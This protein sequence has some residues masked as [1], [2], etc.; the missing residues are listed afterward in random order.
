VS[1]C[2]NH[3]GASPKSGDLVPYLVLRL[4]GKVQV[5]REPFASD[6]YLW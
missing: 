6:F 5:L 3:Q 2:Q 4:N 1:A